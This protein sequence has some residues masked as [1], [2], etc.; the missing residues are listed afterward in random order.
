MPGAKRTLSA[1]IPLAEVTVEVGFLP[2]TSN[3]EIANTGVLT[4]NRT[5][6]L[7]V[8]LNSRTPV[9]VPSPSSSCLTGLEAHGKGNIDPD[10]GHSL[11]MG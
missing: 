5:T 1:A 10:L 7:A 6:A 2:L 4:F 3:K 8:P 9:A 11:Q